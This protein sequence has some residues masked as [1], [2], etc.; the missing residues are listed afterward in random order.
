MGN[1]VLGKIPG[2][3]IGGGGGG[4]GANPFKTPWGLFEGGG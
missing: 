2:G 1:N 4:G 3:Y